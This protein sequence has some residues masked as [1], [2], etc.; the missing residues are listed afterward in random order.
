MMR[1]HLLGRTGLRVSPIALGAMTFG[2][3]GWHAGEDTAR[4]IFLRYLEAGG[5]FIDTADIYAGGRSEELL[6]SFMKKT[7]T[8]DRLVVATKFTVATTPGDPNSGGNGR[9]NILASLDASL[10]RLDTDYVDLYWLHMWDA[11]TPVEEVMATFDTLVRSGKVRA[12]GLSN[13]PAWYAAKAQL[14]AQA[15]GWEPVAAL[16]LE[17]SLAERSIEREHIPAAADLGIGVI[18]WS[19][20]ANG[21][22]TGK[23]ARQRT[24]RPNGS[25]RLTKMEAD[26]TL[27]R[28]RASGN[29]T[30]T[31]L[32]TER[33]WRIVDLLSEVARE[34]GRSPAQVAL[35]W[36]TRR[37][38]VVST[39]VGATS[40]DQ[41]DENLRALDF[42]IPR[43]FAER[44]DEAS[45]PEDIYP[46][47]FSGTAVQPMING[48]PAAVY[49]T[50]SWPRQTSI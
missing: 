18:P 32:F 46:Y 13:I 14:L 34:I 7:T 22:L 21:L 23:Y 29:P 44:L 2:E 5:N 43:E 1:Y 4:S 8:R 28:T 31:K 24:E 30:F 49:T 36:V 42:E 40:A 33:T 11:M 45:R 41:L 37:P 25:G 15:R 19:P 12:V 26:G 38:A 17:Y 6:G 50:P 20:L 16:Q 47:Y 35:N 3:G 39:L 10:R 27:E 48:G 9:K